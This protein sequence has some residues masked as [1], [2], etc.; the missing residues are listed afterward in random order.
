[1]ARTFS[2]RRLFI[3]VTTLCVVAGIGVNFP[4]ATLV[5]VLMLPHLAVMV[6]CAWLICIFSLRRRL[7]F[8]ISL[9]GGLNGFLIAPRTVCDFRGSW[10]DLYA[11]T[12]MDDTLCTAGGAILMGLASLWLFG[13]REIEPVDSQHE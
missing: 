13:A 5:A 8:A 7:S 6:V 10:W 4:Q 9:F 2:L 11:T 1:M 3:G 12:F